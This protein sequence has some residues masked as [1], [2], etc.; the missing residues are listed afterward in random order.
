[1]S[2]GGSPDP[3]VGAIVGGVVAAVVVI[4]VIAAIIFL[5]KRK[6]GYPRKPLSVSLCIFKG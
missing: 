6:G 3:D 4:V 2:G 1:M 5:L